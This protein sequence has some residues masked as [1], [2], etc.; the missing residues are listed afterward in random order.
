MNLYDKIIASG[1][2]AFQN[3]QDSLNINNV[4]QFL[5]LLGL[6]LSRN[7]SKLVELKD[8]VYFQNFQFYLKDDILIDDINY[9]VDPYFVVIFQYI[10]ENNKVNDQ[11]QKSKVISP[12]K[13]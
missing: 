13:Y 3:E 8:K 9:L 4:I 12:K 7:D 11:S 10:K 5:K 1:L 6:K 2:Y